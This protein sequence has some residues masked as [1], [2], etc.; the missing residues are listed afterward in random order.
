MKF[1][2][3]YYLYVILFLNFYWVKYEGKVVVD[4]EIYG[5]VSRGGFMFFG[6]ILC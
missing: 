1:Y 3:N 6:W 5:S 4:Y 2:R